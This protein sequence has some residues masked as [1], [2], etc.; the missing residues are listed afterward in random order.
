MTPSILLAP[1]SKG[2]E[3]GERCTSPTD[4]EAH[5]CA[6]HPQRQGQGSVGLQQCLL[7]LLN[8]ALAGKHG[9]RPGIS[10]GH[11]CVPIKLYSQQQ[12]TEVCTVSQQGLGGRLPSVDPVTPTQVQRTHCCGTQGPA[13]PQ[14]RAWPE[15]TPAGLAEPAR[16]PGAVN[17]QT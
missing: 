17:Q 2:Q 14:E 10:S 1:G 15:P 5:T 7:H 11:S 6:V 13:V 4:Q 12:V 16:T 3:P 9:H 8:S